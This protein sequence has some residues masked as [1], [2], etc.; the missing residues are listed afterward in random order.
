MNTFKEKARELADSGD[1]DLPRKISFTDKWLSTFLRKF[2]LQVTSLPVDSD[3]EA[4]LTD[5]N[6]NPQWQDSQMESLETDDDDGNNQGET[7]NDL[8]LIKHAQLTD[9]MRAALVVKRAEE[10]G[11]SQLQLANWLE[12]E[13]GIKV[14]RATIGRNL[15]R[16]S[17]DPVI[18]DAKRQF[19]E[20]SAIYPELEGRL[21][22]WWII[23]TSRGV[24]QSLFT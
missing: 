15:K 20:S 17:T 10:P 22:D 21:V 16:L 14:H 12:A 3:G 24:S 23:E 9:E 5:T 18:R 7:Q 11:W 1:Y 8:G 6:G 13:Y 4:V 2:N 19:S